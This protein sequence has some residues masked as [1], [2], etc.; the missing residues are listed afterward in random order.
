MVTNTPADGALVGTPLPAAQQPVR[1]TVAGRE[2]E[3]LYAGGAPGL[4]AGLL[5]VNIKLPPNVPAG[6]QPV[7]LTVGTASSPAGVTLAVR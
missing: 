5:Q 2:A 6:N 7:V 1:V 3:V 4:V